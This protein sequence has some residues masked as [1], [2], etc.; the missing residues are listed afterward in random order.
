MNKPVAIIT[1]AASGLGLEMA[2]QLTAE[3]QLYLVDVQADKL[4]ALNQQFTDCKLFTCDLS[5]MQSVD[6]LVAQISQHNPNIGLLINN[7]GI[8][9]RSQVRHTQAKVIEQVMA[10]D[11][12]APVRLTQGLLPRL[13][14]CKSKIVNISSMAGWMPVLGRAGYCA[15]KSALH[16]YFETLRGELLDSGLTV[17]M[18]YPSFIDTPINQNALGGDGNQATHPRSTVGHIHSA[19]WMVK[20]IVKAI[21]NNK[22]RLFPEPLTLVFSLLYRLWPSLFMRLMR[23]KFATELE[24][25]S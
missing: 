9:H 11:F 13:L 21:R 1:G 5:N 23:R 3:Y 2:K 6:E 17:L 24:S 16:Q 15:A 25:H 14:E 8:T 10:V 12:H 18:V 20:K 7:A 19:N 4:N 22:Q